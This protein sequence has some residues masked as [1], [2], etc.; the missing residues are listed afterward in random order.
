MRHDDNSKRSQR[1]WDRIATSGARWF[2]PASAE[3]IALARQDEWTISVTARRPVP[4]KWLGAVRNRDILCLAGGGGLQGPILAAAGARVTV[5]DFSSGQLAIDNAIARQF[6]LTL[7]TLHADM[8]RLEGIADESFDIVINPCSVNFCP[9]VGPVWHE[10]VR[11]LRPGGILIAGLLNPVNY[12]FDPLAMERNEFVV[13][14]KIPGEV[15]YDPNSE[16]IPVEYSHELGELIG[17]QLRAG[18]AITGFFEDRWGGKD[19]LSEKIA[20]FIA[21]RAIRRR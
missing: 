11:V 18:L 4:Q 15:V 20:V 16:D 1:A 3:S 14:H 21:T 2:L 9:N 17:G 19:P 5:A 10:V 8:R 6:G 7:T 12:L 13:A